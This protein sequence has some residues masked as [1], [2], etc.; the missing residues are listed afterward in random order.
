MHD[1]HHLMI[2]VREDVAVPYVTARFVK[3][4]LNTRD[5]AWQ[6]CADCRAMLTAAAA[7]ERRSEHPLARAVIQAAEANDLGGALPAAES[8]EAVA[9]RGVRGQLN[10]HGITVGDHAYIH[11]EH[12]ELASGPLCD[13]IHAAQDAGQTVMVVRDDCCGVRGY[14]AVADTL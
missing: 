5:L 4:G 12:P 2:L 11:D 10:G 1:T 3:G 9:G 8:V 6:S 13:A 7:V 14:I